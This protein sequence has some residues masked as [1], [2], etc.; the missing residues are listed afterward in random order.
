MVRTAP[1]PA[2][3]YTFEA[4]GEET[5]PE[6]TQF[7][8]MVMGDLPHGV[9]VLPPGPTITAGLPLRLDVG[10]ASD[11]AEAVVHGL[12]GGEHVIAI[13]RFPVDA[14][15]RRQIELGTPSRA[16]P[17]QIIIR[18]RGREFARI[19][20]VAMFAQ[21]KPDSSI[22][23]SSSAKFNAGLQIVQQPRGQVVVEGSQVLLSVE[24]RSSR[25]VRYVWHK[26]GVAM[27]G[28][29]TNVLHLPKLGMADAGSYS[30]EV[31]N[32]IQR[33]QSAPAILKVLVSSP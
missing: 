26:D 22:P 27:R 31:S 20:T 16:G 4:V 32:G 8:M 10:R 29:N 33:L 15:G 24:V 14:S 18:E 7:H 11:A 30:V 3:N 28:P 21:T 23:A 12:D 2:G 1:L 9:S 17:I 25:P 19:S 5:A 13:K 6:G